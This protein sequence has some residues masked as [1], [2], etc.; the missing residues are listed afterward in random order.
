MKRQ[1]LAVQ[2]S[3]LM[4]CVAWSGIA[5]AADAAPPPTPVP[6]PTQGTAQPA[7]KP[8]VF[9]IK[10]GWKFDDDQL[11]FLNANENA[12]GKR[13]IVWK[14]YQWA[15]GDG[16]ITI[17][18]T[19]PYGTTFSSNRRQVDEDGKPMKDKDVMNDM[20]DHAKDIREANTPPPPP[21]PPGYYDDY[22]G[23]PFI[24]SSFFF[25]HSG[26]HRRR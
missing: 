6:A 13:Y 26:G 15:I 16:Q 4:V 12:D 8:P 23:R 2:V 10:S 5:C 21:P 22:Y 1:L 11:V 24:G 3:C 20:K 19:R 14:D 7:A 25:F 17:F 9:E 18:D